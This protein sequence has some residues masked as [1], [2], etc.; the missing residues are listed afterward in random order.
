MRVAGGTVVLLVW[1]YGYLCM[2]LVASFSRTLAE[3]TCSLFCQN[4]VCIHTP[5]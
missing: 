5:I 2:Y 3:C 1:E 4:Y